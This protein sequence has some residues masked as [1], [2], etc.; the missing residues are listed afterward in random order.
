MSAKTTRQAQVKRRA[1][2]K[3]PF[4]LR[5][6]RFS[7]RV[8]SLL[9]TRWAGR[10]LYHLWFT[11]PKH[12][13]PQREKRWRE[14]AVFISVPYQHGPIATYK[15]GDSDKTVLLLHGWSGRG[16]QM[17]AFVAPLLEMGYQVVAFDAPGHGRT[18][19]K[20]S[21]I[22][23]MSDALQAVVEEVGPVSAVIAHSFGAMLLAYALK[24]TDFKTGKAIC[25]SSPTT[26]IFLVDR[27]CEVIQVN[28]KVKQYFMR[29]TEQKF[30]QNVW[31]NLSADKNVQDIQIPALIIHDQDDH[32]V[33]SELGKQL[34]EAWSNSQFY[35]TKG[36]GHRRILRN[37]DVVRMIAD[38][39]NDSSPG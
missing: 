20:S 13:E 7:F 33:P 30:N 34:S 25:I 15:W 26:P 37:K 27:F 16:P 2:R 31:N 24:H 4:I 6:L 9:S 11:S 5:W 12:P 23:R 19:G 39:I 29:Y 1:R 18:P 10:R 22:F 17:G 36:L 21:S 3:P 28:D 32:D 35:L 14:S 38:Y 8:Q